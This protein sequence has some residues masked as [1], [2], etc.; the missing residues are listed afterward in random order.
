MKIPRSIVVPMMLALVTV[1]LLNAVVTFF[2]AVCGFNELDGLI[3]G[4]RLMPAVTAL[5]RAV[6]GLGW[7]IPLIAL[8]ATVWL[9]WSP[10]RPA[11]H[12]V[13]TMAILTMTVVGWAVFAF[14]AL[15]ALHVSI[16]YH[17]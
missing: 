4:S 6:Y 15:C 12:V 9:V 8:G 5:F 10:D 7:G 17:I 13:W 1:A 3:G 16:G 14:V 11:A 2:V